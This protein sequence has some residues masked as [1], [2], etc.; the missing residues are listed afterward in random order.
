M[1]SSDALSTLDL[2]ALSEPERLAFYGALFAMSDADRSMDPVE[3]ERI[4]ETLD[5]SGLSGDARRQVLAQAIQPP[6]L[7]RCLLQLKDAPAEIR[8]GLMLNL[9]DIV[10][11]DGSIEPG[12]HMGLL[13]ARQ[14]LGLS[15]DE[16]AAL[17]EAAHTAQQ[18]GASK[19]LQRPIGLA[20]Q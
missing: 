3:T 1:T 9:I 14:V 19:S 16:V 20:S 7:E 17:H 13:Q 6:P 2:S 18:S 4:E 11:A 8:R 15:H 10:L 5:L 12:E